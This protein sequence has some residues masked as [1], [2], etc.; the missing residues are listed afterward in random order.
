[1]RLFQML[2][3]KIG[4]LYCKLP[5]GLRKFLY[6]RGNLIIF[7]LILAVA[8]FSYILL[9]TLPSFVLKIHFASFEWLII[10]LIILIGLLSLL[11]KKTK[12]RA[13]CATMAVCA[14]A[15]C[16]YNFSTID[17]RIGDIEIASPDD[18]QILNRFDSGSFV[19]TDDISFADYDV[20]PVKS[21]KGTLDGCGYTIRDLKLE[22][23]SFINAN[24][25]TV[26]DINISGLS[27]KA[28]GKEIGFIGVNNG[29]VNGISVDGFTLK[30]T[31][32]NN[33]GFIPKS[34]K[35]LDNIRIY[36]AAFNTDNC[37]NV[38]VITGSAANLSECS[39]SGSIVFSGK[40]EAVGGLVG[41]IGSESAAVSK[42]SGN[43]ALS[44]NITKAVNV[45]G[46][47][48]KSS[49]HKIF[50]ECYSQGAVALSLATEDEVLFGG[51]CGYAEAVDLT[52]SA[53]KGD[54]TLS[55]NGKIYAGG[56]VGGC[57]DSSLMKLGYSY[58]AGKVNLVSGSAVY[59][60]FVGKCPEIKADTTSASLQR[61]INITDIIFA[62]GSNL[63]YNTAIGDVAAD[64]FDFIT[65]CYFDGL[66]TGE[67][68]QG[69]IGGDVTDLMTKTF[70]VNTLG[71][72]NRIWDF[73]SGKV[74]LISADNFKPSNPIDTD[75]ESDK[76]Y[77]SKTIDI[78]PSTL[79][80]EYVEKIVVCSDTVNVRRGPAT[81]YARITSLKDKTEVTAVAEQNGWTLIRLEEG[82][83]WIINDYLK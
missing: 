83:G 51:I 17:D 7:L 29:S 58:T 53:F 24:S 5:F 13:I 63:K 31:K 23:E 60:G 82:Y 62:D 48:G 56:L 74:S 77:S 65:E 6:L 49:S 52:N 38:G 28:N 35:S 27:I 55:G 8:L 36:N 4:S 26:T 16:W 57:A 40:S 75:T 37:K 45:G 72:N 2:K 14:I 18:F 47:I 30:A 79:L 22:N 21:F 73:D 41:V 68:E 15:L 67:S 43:V 44:S 59:G 39:A 42:C 80:D 12:L 71:W 19:L 25:G 70:C 54:I 46:L 81:K 50:S 76:I 10:T 33:V 11:I 32:A 61:M 66:T 64:K 3:N 69:L 20:K 78:Y 1:M 9:F 34:S